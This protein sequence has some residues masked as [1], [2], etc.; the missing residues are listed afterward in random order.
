MMFCSVAVTMAVPYSVVGRWSVGG[1]CAGRRWGRGA[2]GFGVAVRE[3]H[4]RDHRVG[5]RG[6]RERTA[7]PDPHALG[8][9]ELAVRAGDAG[10]RVGAH[11]ARAHLVGG[12]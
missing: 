5:P 1:G 2:H 4:D 10:L 6:G 3:G 8:V 11:P 7:V 12:E 9:M